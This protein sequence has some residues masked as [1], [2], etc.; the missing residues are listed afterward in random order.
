[1]LHWDIDQVTQVLGVAPEHHANSGYEFRFE[2]NGLP[3]RMCVFPYSNEVAFSIFVQQAKS[4]LIQWQLECSEIRF[5][6]AL[7]DPDDEAGIAIVFDPIEQN[8][9][10]RPTHW[11]CVSRINDTFQIQ[12]VFRQCS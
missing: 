12:T 5:V 3:A 11:V 7:D 2:V 6:D 10:Q 9:N 4:P 1:M 8:V